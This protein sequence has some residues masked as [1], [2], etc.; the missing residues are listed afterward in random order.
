MALTRPIATPH[1]A[2]P[3]GVNFSLADRGKIIRCV[4]TVGGLEK[5]AQCKLTVSE[6]E[7]IFLAHRDLIESTASRKYDASR[8]FYSPMT[9]SAADLVILRNRAHLDAV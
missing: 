2:T 3:G 1:L 5:L 9:V 4:I 7:R 6:F 8:T